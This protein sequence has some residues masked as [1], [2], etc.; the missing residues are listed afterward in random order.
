[1]SYGQNPPGPHPYGGQ[2]QQPYGQRPYGG[3]PPNPYGGQPPQ[4]PYGPPPQRNPYGP[5]PQPNSYGPPQNP[6]GRPPGQ[7][8]AQPPRGGPNPAGQQSGKVPLAEHA[9]PVHTLGDDP[10]SFIASTL[11]EVI[12]VALRPRTNDVGVLTRARQEAVARCA[13]MAQAAGADAVVGLRF[14]SNLEEI[15]AYGTA[16]EFTDEVELSD[17]PDATPV[18]VFPPPDADETNAPDGATDPDAPEGRS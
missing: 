10:E 1:M 17:V 2:P 3:Q 12:G 15:V 4:N 7:D 8:Q 9:V 11:G 6:Y 5:G 16:V 14:D 18:A 13:E